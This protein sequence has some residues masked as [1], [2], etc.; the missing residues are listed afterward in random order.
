V[1][2]DAEVSARL[3]QMTESIKQTIGGN[4]DPWEHVSRMERP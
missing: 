4:A 3:S 1:N 2:L